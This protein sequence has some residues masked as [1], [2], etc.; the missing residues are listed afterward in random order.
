MTWWVHF[1]A[2][3]VSMRRIP[4][5]QVLRW[6]PPGARTYGLWIVWTRQVYH[7][8]NSIPLRTG[9][10]AASDSFPLAVG[11]QQPEGIADPPTPDPPIVTVS[12]PAGQTSL[13][14]EQTLVI[15]GQATDGSGAASMVRINGQ[16]VR[17]VGRGRQFLSA[18]SNRSGDERL[19]ARG[20][21]RRGGDATRTVTVSGTQL[22]ADTVDF[23]RLSVVSGST[24][25]VY[26]RT[27]WHD[28]DNILYA[29]FGIQNIGRYTVDGPVLVGVT[30]IS[31]PSVP[32]RRRP[33]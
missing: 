28:A 29:D 13:P 31:D 11:N 12:T 5:R 20:Q 14:A 9:S 32:L 18:D 33:P 25:G 23:S 6:T 15:T 1:S 10:R 22:A 7:Y 3:G 8:A 21:Q 26:G 30:N 24:F 27:S 19:R 2:A 17:G 4:T 16:S